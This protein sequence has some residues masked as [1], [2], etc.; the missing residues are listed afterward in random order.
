M[1]DAMR[2]NLSSHA[3]RTSVNRDVSQPSLTLRVP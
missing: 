1:L 3:T 2:S